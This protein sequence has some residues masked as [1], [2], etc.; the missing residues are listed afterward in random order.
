MP[1]AVLDNPVRQEQT[2]IVEEYLNRQRLRLAAAAAAGCS[3]AKY[4]NMICSSSGCCERFDIDGGEPR[5]Q[6]V[7]CDRRAI[8]MKNRGRLRRRSQRRHQQR[9]EQADDESA[10]VGVGLVVRN[11]ALQDAKP[12][13]L[14]RKPKPVVIPRC[15]MFCS[16]LLSRKLPKGQEARTSRT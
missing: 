5:H 12:A 14:S 4:Q 1:E 13:A 10:A 11:Q 3:T 7:G 2:A 15:S 9:V 6:P 8:P 16:V